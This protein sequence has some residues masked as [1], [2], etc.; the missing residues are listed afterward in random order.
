MSHTCVDTASN[1]SYC[2]FYVYQYSYHKRRAVI[3]HTTYMPTRV[4]ASMVPDLSINLQ[5][6]RRYFSPQDIYSPFVY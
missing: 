3:T 5:Q 4:L 1:P 2:M 6:A